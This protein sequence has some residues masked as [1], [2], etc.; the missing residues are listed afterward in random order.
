MSARRFRS[1]DGITWT[2]WEVVPGRVLGDT[3]L[4]PGLASG[5]LCFESTAEK[6]RLYPVPPRWQERPEAELWLMCRVAESVRRHVR[7]IAAIGD[8]DDGDVA[9]A[10][11]DAAA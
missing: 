3:P 9:R 7:P 8:V 4:P 11:Q 5:W 2:A 1:P 10:P 6:R